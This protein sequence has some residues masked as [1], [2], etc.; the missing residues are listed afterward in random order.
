MIENAGDVDEAKLNKYREYYRENHRFAH[1]IVVDD[2]THV[3]LDG[4]M[5]YLIAK[6]HEKVYPDIMQVKRGQV[7]RK[8]IVGKLEGEDRINVWYY[9]DGP[10]VC[11]GDVIAA[12][13]GRRMEVESIGYVA[14]KYACE[15][16]KPWAL[17]NREG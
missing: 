7:F 11:P 16:Y 8:I 3:L 17:E 10:A 2:E 1:G 13:D 4:Y 15:R 6:E 5:S 12:A 14:G 9:D